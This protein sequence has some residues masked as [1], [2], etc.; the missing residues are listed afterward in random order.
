MTTVAAPDIIRFY[1]ASGEFG[2]LSNLYPATVLMPSGNPESPLRSFLTAEHAYQYEKFL[3]P[4]QAEI[5]MQ[6]EPA[7]L[8][9][10]AHGLLPWQVRPDWRE[11]KSARMLAVLRAKFSQHEDLRRLL[12]S[13]GDAKLLEQSKFDAFW[14]VGKKGN[15][16]NMLGVML[17]ELRS[18]LRGVWY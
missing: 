16:L 13:T 6:L 15:G 2:W 10:L 1:R 7:Y 18:E 4:T 12:L 8:A 9:V 11:Y 3:D 5:A 17:M 14:G